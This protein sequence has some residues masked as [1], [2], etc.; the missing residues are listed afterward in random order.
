[1]IPQDSRDSKKSGKQVRNDIEGVIQ[2]D[3]EEI[4][5]LFFWNVVYV[6]GVG[7]SPRREPGGFRRSFVSYKRII[8]VSDLLNVKRLGIS[9]ALCGMVRRQRG[10][11][12]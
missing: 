6:L 5:V 12:V 10:E 9:C 3:G 4:F 2:V 11:Q 8:S 1:M 7:K